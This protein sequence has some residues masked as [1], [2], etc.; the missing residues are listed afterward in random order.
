M[1]ENY[2]RWLREQALKLGL[3][4]HVERVYHNE[5]EIMVASADLDAIKK[6]KEMI[7]QCR[8]AQVKRIIEQD[9]TSAIKIG[10]EVNARSDIH[11]FRS[12]QHAFRILIRSF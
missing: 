7:A 1:R 9:G 2:H 3:H 11:C 8:S 10:F 4:G 12:A 5:I 6:F